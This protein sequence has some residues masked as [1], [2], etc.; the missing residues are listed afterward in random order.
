LG[1]EAK[2]FEAFHI[3]IIVSQDKKMFLYD[4]RIVFSVQKGR[5]TPRETKARNFGGF[6]FGPGPRFVRLFSLSLGESFNQ[7]FLL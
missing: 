1:R 5:K 3:R 4:N 6:I 2:K 7:F